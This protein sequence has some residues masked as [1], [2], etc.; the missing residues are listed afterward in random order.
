[1]SEPRKVQDGPAYGSP[2]TAAE[3]HLRAVD[4][5][6]EGLPAVD[7]TPP[8]E[9]EHGTG[10]AAGDA[11]GTVER[12]PVDAHLLKL[13]AAGV[14]GA[15]G[16]DGQRREVLPPWAKDR[17]ILGQV[18]RRQGGA[19]WHVVAFRA[20]RL[21]PDLLRILW[22]AATGASRLTRRI[23]R[24][25]F[26]LDGHPL[27]GDVVASTDSAYVR[28]ANDRSARMRWR[29][30]LLALLTVAGV[31]GL[32]LV[33]VMLPGL[34]L[35]AG[36][37]VAVA[38]LASHG[39]P[40]GARFLT[41]AVQRE[42][43]I[44]LTSQ[45]IIRALSV[46]GIGSLSKALADRPDSI[47]R[48]G[49]VAVRG[50]HKV[51]IQLPPGTV[52][53]DLLAHEQRM[54]AALGRQADCVVVEPAPERTPGD[55]TLWILDRPVLSARRGAGP[56]AKARRTS[57]WQPVNIG[58]T[59]LGSAFPLHLR[60]GAWFIGGQPAAGKS[61]LLKI[62]AAHTALD[63][64]ALLTV[65]N[66]KG[67]PDYAG[68]RNVCHRYLSGSPET[69]PTV[70]GEAVALLRE[71][72]ADCARRNDLLTSLVEKGEA[73]STDVTEEL[74]RK[75]PALRPHTVVLDEVHRLFDKADNP[76]A[77][78]TAE[79]IGRIIK[80]VRSVGYTFIAATQLAGGESVPPALVRAS[81]V[82][83]CLKVQ[84]EV[85]FRQIFGN[86]GKGTFAES[87]VANLPPG[88]VMLKSEDGG[89]VKVGTWLIPTTVLA[90]VGQRARALREGMHLL[91]GDAAG[92]D[93]VRA[94]ETDPADLLRHAL[95]LVP[96]TAPARG[97]EDE[98][99]AWLTELED[100]LADRHP[101]TY[102]D[103]SPG[104]LSGELRTRNVTTSP[105]GRRWT[106][107]GEARQRNT[108]GVRSGALRDA[109]DKL[110]P[111]EDG[112]ATA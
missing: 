15:V 78:A 53:A 91:T 44:P 24:W 46:L 2:E 111:A 75:Y 70:I 30:S 49:I 62:A 103:R 48:S 50:G 102:G 52:A 57:W 11:L 87:G 74:A 32:V 99:V 8:A 92:E 83:G 59:R 23:G 43:K 84:D 68:V 21:V 61:S 71:V 88:T 101:D 89:S 34:V 16:P 85:S 28:M 66:L 107:D 25:G 36:L 76:D 35:A 95:A 51:A 47:W 26:D 18:A 86:T 100:A 112:D 20:V 58:L 31:V 4:T 104:W 33:H 109:L 73:T 82:R 108:T 105:V 55:L 7:A 38:L 60:G 45:A 65:V 98:T 64:Y 5:P 17:V 94:V 63:P 80:A 90:E 69:D 42:V 72:L 96:T 1:M 39:K 13:P 19:L 40:A 106:E 22:W 9:A 3:R 77:E 56:L 41:P 27:L 37:A 79:L 97:R 93:R 6:P 81:R 29:L 67:S 12:G 10:L 110:L 54:A 14:T